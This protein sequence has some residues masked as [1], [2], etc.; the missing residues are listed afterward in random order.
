LAGRTASSSRKDREGEPFALVA[1]GALVFDSTGPYYFGSNSNGAARVWIDDQPVALGTPVA[2]DAGVHRLRLEVRQDGKSDLTFGLSMGSEPGKLVPVDAKRQGVARSV[3][4]KDGVRLVFGEAVLFDYNQD[5]LT[6]S[7]VRALSSIF[8]LNLAK[9]PDSYVLVEGHTDNSGG[10]SYNL[11]LSSRRARRVRDWLVSNGRATE[12][13]TFVGHGEGRPR[14][15]N[16]SQE[17]KK[18]NR[19]VELVISASPQAG[20]V[21]SPQAGS[22]EQNGNAPAPKFDGGAVAPTAGGVASGVRGVL[23]AYYQGLNGQ[24]FDAN[25]YFEPFVERYITMMGTNPSA[26]NQYMQKIF[27]TQFKEPHFEYEPDSLVEESPGTFVYV[28]RARYILAG[29]GSSIS[30]RYQVRIRLGSSGKLA[31]LHQF[32]KLPL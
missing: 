20:G 11:D 4:E 27:P 19:R 28:E 26:M 1:D 12:R 9:T 14:V 15:P 5:V 23:D 10:S 8:V 24:T 7:A 30:K 13:V 32:K 3:Q 6:P 17:H 21:S 2:L 18:A 22:P 29:K 16:D 25:V 31:F